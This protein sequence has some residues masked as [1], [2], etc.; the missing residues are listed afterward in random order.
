MQRPNVWDFYRHYKTP[1]WTDRIYKIVGIARHSEN[2]E[3][4]VVYMPLYKREP[5]ERSYWFDMAVRPLSMWFEEVE[6]NGQKMQRFI[7][8]DTQAF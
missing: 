1:E 5:G 8:I 3:E 6:V 7:Q 4:L 2:D